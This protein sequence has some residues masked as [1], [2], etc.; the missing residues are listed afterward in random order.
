M[1]E[2]YTLNTPYTREGA[3]CCLLSH[4][5]GTGFIQKVTK[6]SLPESDQKSMTKCVN[7]NSFRIQLHVTQLS[8]MYVSSPVYAVNNLSY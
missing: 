2:L 6:L 3:Y 5:Q 8:S 1:C 4:I 7:Y